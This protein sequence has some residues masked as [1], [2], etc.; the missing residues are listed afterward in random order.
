MLD[1]LKFSW[2]THKYLTIYLLDD[3]GCISM[4]PLMRN[5]VSQVLICRGNF[6]SKVIVDNGA[7]LCSYSLPSVGD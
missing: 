1:E 6:L 2:I 5:V 4:R 7:L 3:F